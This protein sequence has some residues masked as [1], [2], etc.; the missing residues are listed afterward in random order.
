MGRKCFLN[1]S[2]MLTFMIP[3]IAKE[4]PDAR[5][6]HLIR[7]G[8]AVA[9][10]YAIKQRKKINDN[11]SAYAEQGFDY[12]FKDLLRACAK[13]WRLQMK[14]V[15][16]HTKELGFR[17][18]GVFFELKYEDF[19]RKPEDFLI[20]IAAF[21]GVDSAPFKGMGLSHIKTTNY[22]YREERYEGFI[23]EISQLMEPT[24]RIKGYL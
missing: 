22:K 11:L 2:A 3:F 21:M 18:R 10:S 4:F 15:E 20:Q 1:K 6:I 5:F 9:L 17:E 24:L 23:Q 14:E 12:P 8:R 16:R 7:D 13:S 19:C